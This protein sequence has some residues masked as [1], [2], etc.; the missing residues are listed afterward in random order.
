MP[1]LT[2]HPDRLFPAEASTRDVARRLYETV[3]DLPIISPHGHV[4]PQWIAEN[5]PWTDPTSLLLSPDHYINRLL[6]AH[7]VQLSSLGVPPGKVTL[8]D[9]EA[10]A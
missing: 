6:H 1:A 8:S 3:K 4:P 9:A 5:T 2:L 10:R 7:G